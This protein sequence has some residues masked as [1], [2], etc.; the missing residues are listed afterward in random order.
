MWIG[1]VRVIVANEEGRL[2]LVCQQHEGR[3]IWMLPGG[4]IEEGEDA[5]KAAQREV[6]E[7]TGLHVSMGDL[8]WH[9]EEVSPKRGQR[10]VNYFIADI[11]DGELM[12]GRD[13][14]LGQEG[15]VLRRAVFMSRKDIEDIE[16]LHPSFL[17]DEIWNIIERS[18]NGL[19]LIHRIYR[20]REEY[21]V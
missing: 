1:G 3:E 8:I 2:L 7:E 5:A 4:G 12:L 17:R 16:Y 21:R 14:E 15:Q 9:V 6:F 18:K 19:P 11:L 20:I 13:P 10:F